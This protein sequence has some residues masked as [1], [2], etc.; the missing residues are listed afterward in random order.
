[1]GA[2]KSLVLYFIHLFATNDVRF[3]HVW[4]HKGCF[5]FDKPST[6]DEANCTFVY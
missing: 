4:Y 2:I 5:V 1:M 6:V 3:F